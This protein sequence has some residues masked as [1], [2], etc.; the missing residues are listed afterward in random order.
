MDVKNEIK[1]L[2]AKNA[3]TLKEVCIKLESNKGTK[4]SPNN[5]TNK[6]RRKTIKFTEVADIL[7]ILDYR[8]DFIKKGE[9]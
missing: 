9:L 6:L 3:T 2:I 7:E 1:S 4:I 8:I 5:I